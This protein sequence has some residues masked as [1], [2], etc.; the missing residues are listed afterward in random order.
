MSPW[1]LIMVMAGYSANHI[2]MPSEAA[3][4]SAAKQVADAGPYTRAP[5]SVLCV[6]REDP[7]AKTTEESRPG[8]SLRSATCREQMIKSR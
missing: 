6:N 3:C 7:V 1:I 2:D 8:C 5:M 4:R